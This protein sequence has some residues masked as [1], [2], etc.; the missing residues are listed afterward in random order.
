MHTRNCLII[1]SG[2][3]FIAATLLSIASPRHLNFL[4]SLIDQSVD[5]LWFHI[6]STCEINIFYAL[7]LA[8]LAQ[9]DL[10]GVI[11]PNWIRGTLKSI[12]PCSDWGDK[13]EFEVSL[14]AALRFYSKLND[15]VSGFNSIYG[16]LLVGIKLLSLIAICFLLYVPIRHST[17]I[18]FSIAIFLIF[19]VILIKL[20]SYIMSMGSV[21]TESANFKR[22]WIYSLGNNHLR[23]KN[24]KP[25]FQKLCGMVHFHLLPPISFCSG[26]FYDIQPSTILTFLS[27]ATTYII[28]A[29]QV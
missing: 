26:P 6:L 25:Y 23:H 7:I 11:F 17:G 24:G 8:Q 4:Y 21:Y 15:L 22:S 9:F 2:C 28:V 19:S 5:Y 20:S 3:C 1:L 12:S 27:I 14:T 29:L 16:N 10:V 13:D 18:A